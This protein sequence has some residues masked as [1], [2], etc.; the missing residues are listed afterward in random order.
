MRLPGRARV[1]HH[2]EH[3]VK[4][5]W[6]LSEWAASR[7]Q[8]KSTKSEPRQPGRRKNRVSRGGAKTASAGAAQKPRQPG[9]HE[10]CVSRGGTEKRKPRQP[11][12][13]QN[14][15]KKTG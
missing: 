6:R 15:E 2:P 10:N 14:E 3:C 11:G 4:Q 13:H 1:R 5:T 9:R 7:G 12:R 8:P